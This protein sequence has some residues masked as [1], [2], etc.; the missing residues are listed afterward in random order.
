[1]QLICCL[2]ED[3]YKLVN[4]S[5]QKYSL[6]HKPNFNL[7]FLVLVKNEKKNMKRKLNLN[8]NE[9]AD[10]LYFLNLSQQ[11]KKTSLKFKTI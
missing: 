2:N 11:E 4:G 3:K 8:S 5:K 1:M 7:E 9:V 10:N 6:K